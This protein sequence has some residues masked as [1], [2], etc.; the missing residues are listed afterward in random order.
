[1]SADQITTDPEILRSFTKR[2]LRDL[3][4]LDLILRKGIIEDDV[5]RI[6]AEQELFLVDQHL[7]PYPCNLELLEKIDN[8]VFTTELAR[9]NMEINLEPL[10]YRDN[11]LSLLHS[12]ISTRLQFAAEKAR[13]IDCRLILIGS[14]PTIRKSDLDISNLTPVLRYKVLNQA[15]CSLR[16]EHHELNIKGSDELYLRHDSVMLEACNTSFQVHFQV[17]PK[18]FTNLY[19]IAQLVAGPVLAAAANSPLLFG[20][21]LWH[22]TRIPVFQQSIDMRRPGSYAVHQEPRVGF[23]THWITGSILDIYR[24]DL[25]R[26]RVIMGLKDLPDSIE[27]VERGEIPRLRALQLY[28]STVYRWNRPCYGITN[29]RPHLRIENRVLP[30]GPTPADETANAAFWLGLL[31]GLHTKYGDVTKLIEFD[32][33]RANFVAAARRG[34]LAQFKWFDGKYLSAQQLILDKLLGVAEKGLQAANLLPADIRTYLGIIEKRV[35]NS[36]NGALWQLESWNNLSPKYS[37]FEKSLYLTQAYHEN[38]INDTPVGDW[39][40]IK[41]P[42]MKIQKPRVIKIEQIMSRD[43]FSLHEDDVIDLAANIMEWRKI[44]S[45]P[46]IDSQGRLTGLLTYRNVIELLNKVSRGILHEQELPVKAL[47]EGTET[48]TTNPETPVNEALEEMTEHDL[49]CL[50]VVKDEKLVGIVTRS[51]FLKVLSNLM[52]D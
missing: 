2:L 12:D 18:E 15:L 24:E 36:R 40:G 28:N 35:R 21:K 31:N 42:T 48:F 8:P 37:E 47:I 46:V 43:V 6:G 38:H 44:T 45:I 27:E 33:V 51:D 11:C 9:F 26:F 13:E 34:L 23:G 4:A 39:P 25:S 19:N 14:L 49:I 16:S 3:E 52:S 30:S 7:Q 10:L 32:E 29:N 22:E 5:V 20:R 1:M 17:S 41:A 50:P